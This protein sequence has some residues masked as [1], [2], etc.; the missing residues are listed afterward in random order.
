MDDRTIRIDAG[1]PGGNIIVDQVDGDEVRLHQDLR[2]TASD[3]FYWCFRLRNAAGRRLR[4]VFTRSRALGVRGPA[5][6][7]DHGMTW[8][9]IGA[10][11]VQ[12]NS[13]TITVPQDDVR[14]SFGMP[15]VEEHWRQFADGLADSP[16]FEERRLCVTPKGRPVE[17]A[18]L[19]RPDREP[20]HRVAVTARHHCCEM[21]ASYV[22]EGMI[23]R[24]AEGDGPDGV[25]LR[26]NT[27][28]FVVPFA[29][30]DGVED[31]DQ[32]KNRAPRDH[33]RDYLGESLYAEPAAIRK[34]L[35]VWGG[36][37][38][39]VALDLHCP[40]IDGPHNEVIYMVGGPTRECSRQQWAFSEA[41]ERVRTGPL[42]FVAADYLPYGQ[43]WNTDANYERG[44]GFARFAE[45]LPG[46]RLAGSIETPYANA[47]GVEVNAH[48]ARLFGRDL[49]SAI[50]RYLA[51]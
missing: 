45:E 18:L 47:R 14:L 24:I 25:W 40:W 37:R 6:S 22:M 41:I 12:D 16:F 42:P 3:W 50:A 49:A 34:M 26:D 46:V 11:A 43:A 13:F 17:L 30:K 28:F 31:G 4:F 32:G 23:R 48:S 2:D 20:L 29:D 10:A 19:G 9:W 39:H 15:Y 35:P 51:G 27:Q 5:I 36:D 38:L 1:F 44:R 7:L 8:S 21:M 33:G